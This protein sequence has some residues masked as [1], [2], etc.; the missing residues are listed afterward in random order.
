MVLRNGTR[1]GMRKREKGKW[2]E[3][4]WCKIIE[5]IPA[6]EWDK[7]RTERAYERVVSMAYGRYQNHFNKCLVSHSNLFCLR[8]ESEEYFLTF[9]RI[10]AIE[11]QIPVAKITCVSKTTRMK[12]MKG[13]LCHCTMNGCY[14][15]VWNEWKSEAWQFHLRIMTPFRVKLLR[16]SPGC[17]QHTKVSTGMGTY[18][19]KHYFYTQVNSHFTL[20]FGERKVH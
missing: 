10:I 2:R 15:R 3:N 17:K 5:W 6:C 9:S 4:S 11:P 13:N 16:F 19:P 20:I 7:E 1:N 8:D 18:S 12:L 14:L